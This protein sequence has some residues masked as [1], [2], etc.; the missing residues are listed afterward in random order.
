M[1]GRERVPSFQLPSGTTDERDNSYN[2]G[3]VGNI[4]YNTDTSNVEIRHEDPSNSLD[5]R[6]LV[7]NNKEQIDISG[8][9]GI[10]TDNPSSYNRAAVPLE[11]MGNTTIS[12]PTQSNLTNVVGKFSAND[13][14]AVVIGVTNGNAPYIADCNGNSSTSVGLRFLT[15][16]T[17]R[18]RINSDGYLGIGS[19]DPLAPLD[20]ATSVVGTVDVNNQHGGSYMS[21]NVTG[22][23]FS[24][25]Q[26][27]GV[28]V[29]GDG[30]RMVAHGFYAGYSI[31]FQSDR[32]IKKD[33]RE[34]DDNEA[35]LKFRLLKPSKYKYIEPILSCRT[36]GDV[37]GFIAQEVAEVLPDA[38]TIGSADGTN[39]GHIPNIMSMCT[40]TKDSVDTDTYNAMSIE[41]RAEYISDSEKFTRLTVS[42]NYSFDPTTFAEDRYL[43]SDTTKS[44]S[45]FEKNADGEYDP[46]IF[47]N[48][49]KQTKQVK[50]LSVINETTFIIDGLLF[51]ESEMISDNQL[52]LY[53]QK[54]HDF[55]RLNKDAIFTL[56]AA[57]LQEVDRQQQADKVRI[58]ALETQLTSVLSRL[59][60]LENT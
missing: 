54:P 30:G 42:I 45:D 59:D 10:G 35:L 50:I 16:S 37:Y 25:D 19:P 49:H 13:Q 27:V 2:I 18:M 31:N 53:G 23:R 20:V 58:A 57:A 47:Y 26:T 6:D 1:P 8:N 51:D 4:F 3:M 32:R 15:K 9:L 55:H 44:T 40:V 5:W 36:S 11:V 17:E 28:S 22:S 39:Q 46:L 52:L 29:N 56:S 60:A 43:R 12:N 24:N 21:W 48:I 41:Q 38:V 14:A 7:I 34:I 33:I